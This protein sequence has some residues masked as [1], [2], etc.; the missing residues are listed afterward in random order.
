[1]QKTSPFKDSK[2]V[3]LS[4]KDVIFDGNQHYQLIYNPPTQEWNL[5]NCDGY[6]HDLTDE[7]MNKQ[8]KVGFIARLKH[9]F[10]CE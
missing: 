10:D 4:H 8:T 9:L 6:V 1:M 7:I 3:L 2:G 5:I